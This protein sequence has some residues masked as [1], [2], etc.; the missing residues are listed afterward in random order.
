[1][2]SATRREPTGNC[3]GPAPNVIELGPHLGSFLQTAEEWDWRPVGVVCRIRHHC[4]RAQQ[5]T[6]GN[7]RHFG[8]FV[9]KARSIRCGLHL[10][11]FRAT[12]GS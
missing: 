1:M 12:A 6:Q 5:R 3:Y 11:L 10:E 7:S 8:G 4:I 2:H 9:S